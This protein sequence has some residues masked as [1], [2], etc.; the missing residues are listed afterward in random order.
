MK[1]KTNKRNINQYD[2]FGKTGLWINRFQSG[3]IY[4][5]GNFY[6]GKRK[7]IWKSYH[8]NGKL[9][10]IGNYLNG[11]Q[12]DHWKYYYRNGRFREE[13]IFIL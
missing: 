5:T 2:L 4:W 6:K 3:G 9:Y 10:W 8:Q 12:I 1:Q 13:I 11:E 7:G